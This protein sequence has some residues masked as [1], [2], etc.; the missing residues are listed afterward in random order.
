MGAEEYETGRC[1]DAS[2]G[3]GIYGSGLVVNSGARVWG[4]RCR[5]TGHGYAVVLG[6]GEEHVSMYRVVFL[7]G[8]EV[9]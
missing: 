6:R 4:C 1:V 2:V 7:C 9:L 8:S 5:R 3:T